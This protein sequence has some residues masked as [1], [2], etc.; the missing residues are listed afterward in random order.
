MPDFIIDSDPY[1]P[2]GVPATPEQVAVLVAEGTLPADKVADLAPEQQPDDLKAAVAEVIA[3]Q[4][5]DGDA[6]VTDFAAVMKDAGV[7]KTAVTAAVK[8][9]ADAA[10]E[11]AATEVPPVE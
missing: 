2:T 10:A 5:S 8:V 4:I 1:I 9:L 11:V 7:T 3:Q 6:A